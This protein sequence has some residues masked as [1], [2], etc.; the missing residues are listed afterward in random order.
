MNIHLD[1]RIHK[2]IIQTDPTATNSSN[3]S[4]HAMDNVRFY[5]CFGSFHI[6]NTVLCM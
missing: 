5:N 3:L 6:L 1:L 4:F 2:Y